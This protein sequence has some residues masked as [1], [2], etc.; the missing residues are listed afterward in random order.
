MALSNSPPLYEKIPLRNTFQR[1]LEVT[2]LCLLLSLLV[3]RLLTF[4]KHGFA[5]FLALGCE[6][7]FSFIWFLWLNSKWSPVDE[8]ELLS[9]KINDAGRKSVPCDLTGEFAVFSDTERNNHPTIIKVIWENKG[10]SD[11]LPHLIYIS[12]QKLRKHPHRYKAGAMNV[13]TRVSG[14]M[15]NAPFIL[16][17]DCDMYANNPQIIHH[18]MCLLLGSA[19]ERDCGFVQYPQM[20]YDG[21]K[22][23]PFGN[24][25]EVLQESFGPGIGGMQGPVYGGT[26]CF[27]RRKIIY[28]R[29]PNDAKS[30]RKTFP[31]VKG[32]LDVDEL[33]KIFGNSKE[34]VK[35]AAIALSSETG[36]PSNLSNALE[37]AHQVANCD[38]EYGTDW[39]SKVGCL[40]GSTAEDILTGLVI[41]TRG[42]KS[43]Y[44]KPNP[45]A[46]LGCAPSGG[47]SSMMQ[48]K[49]W[50]TGLLEVLLHK[51]CPIF[52]TL[53]GKLQLRQCLAYMLI[54]VW[55]FRSIF[56]VCYAALPAYC[57]ITDSSFLPKVQERAII[58]PVALFVIY[59]IY[60]LSEYLRIGLSIRSWWNNQRMAKI[61][62]TSAWL[63]GFLSVILKIIGLSETVFEITQKDQSFDGDDANAGRFTFNASP[64][65]V[66]GTTLVLL[67]LMAMGLGL[68]GVQPPERHGEQGSGTGEFVC[69]LLVMAY[70]WPFFKGLFGKGKYGIPSSILVKSSALTL[71]F[72]L[73]SR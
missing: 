36:N 32:E 47:P 72:V 53:Y 16:N 2:I 42:W 33:H 70:F 7:W 60:T 4:S 56:E 6:S 45:P 34:L 57:I 66:P 22:D 31:S 65:F 64:A 67:Q 21:I 39:G 63:L 71:L 29:S 38:Y 46:F 11:G 73:F 10:L 62:S 13:L 37:A 58:I 12:R 59:N 23:D 43:V 19:N 54:L 8:Y 26:N 44:C 30:E 41:H 9:R 61:N 15:T 55:G 40:Y 49:R 69:S 14:L 27:H 17:V 48:M 51:N 3:Y 68:F 18:A 20:F 35:S 25:L 28:G 1:A 52:G 24:Q 5:W 50:A